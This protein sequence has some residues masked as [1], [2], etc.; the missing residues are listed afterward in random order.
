MN[1]T[2]LVLVHGEALANGRGSNIDSQRKNAQSL[3]NGLAPVLASDNKI[4]VMHG[5]KP[6]VGFVLFRAELASHVLHSIPLDVCGADT[7]GATGYMLTQEFINTLRREGS[8]R[9]VISVLT[10]TLV[11]T[12]ISS[13]IAPLRAIGPAFDRDKSEHYRLLRNWSIIE[14]PG[15]GYRRGVRSYPV[16][17]VVEIENIKKLIADGNV[18][19]A[20]GGGGVP[21]IKNAKGDLEGIEAVVESEALVPI[22]T[23]QIQAEILMI[24]ISNDRKFILSGLNTQTTLHITSAELEKIIVE[25]NIQS[26]FVQ[27][28][29]IAAQRFIE[30]GGKQVIVCTLDALL[31][32]FMKG[33]GLWISASEMKN[34]PF[35]MQD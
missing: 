2:V 8:H 30:I 20:C 34:K 4:L 14:E 7:Q 25:S 18:V 33:K 32:V 13:D 6:Q 23:E 11:D 22:L 19:V 35:W 31:D 3:A 24:I 15:I 10:Q 9:Q 21:V 27:R 16:K 12:D 28:S 1:Y 17:Q 26:H 29:L 5:N